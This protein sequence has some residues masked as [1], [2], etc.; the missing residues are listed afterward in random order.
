MPQIFAQ[1]IESPFFLH[2]TANC[3]LSG[4]LPLTNVGATTSRPPQIAVPFVCFSKKKNIL[5]P[6]S[7]LPPL[8]SLSKHPDKQKFMQSRNDTERVWAVTKTDALCTNCQRRLANKQKFVQSR[9][10]T[11]RVWA[12]TK[13]DAPCT[14]CQRRL[15]DKRKLAYRSGRAHSLY[16]RR[17]GHG[18]FP[19][20]AA[21]RA[22]IE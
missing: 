12:V 2:N 7:R 19:Y 14:N 1:P 8:H 22:Y 18:G 15:A 20:A 3:G 13:N 21:P 9:N 6:G 5:S 11:E 16:G 4:S 10:D 17:D